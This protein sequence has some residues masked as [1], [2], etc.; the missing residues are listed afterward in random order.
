MHPS[1]I[2]RTIAIA[3]STMCPCSSL[4]NL[5]LQ[6]SHIDTTSAVVLPFCL[7]CSGIIN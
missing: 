5:S 2:T 6:A 7:C 4:T 3:N 1:L